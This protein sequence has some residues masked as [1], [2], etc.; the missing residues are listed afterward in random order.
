M[1]LTKVSNAV[2]SVE[3]G[4]LTLTYDCGDLTDAERFANKAE[5]KLSSENIEYQLDILEDNEEGNWTIVN[6]EIPNIDNYD[7]ELIKNTINFIDS[8]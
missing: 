1:D 5:R 7:F 6:I 3:E 4:V 8:I 2:V